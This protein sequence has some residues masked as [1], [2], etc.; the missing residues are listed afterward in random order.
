LSEWADAQPD[1][2]EKAVWEEEVAKRY[3][4]EEERIVL[5]GEL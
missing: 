5:R 3:V 4:M 2:T 1:T